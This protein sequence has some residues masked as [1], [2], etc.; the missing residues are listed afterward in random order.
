MNK[1]I[2]IQMTKKRSPHRITIKTDPSDDHFCN[3]ELT[4]IKTGEIKATHY[5]LTSDLLT[6]MSFFESDG[7]R[8]TKQL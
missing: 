3:V 5:I 1:L 7:F 6:W 4:K 8:I 2:D